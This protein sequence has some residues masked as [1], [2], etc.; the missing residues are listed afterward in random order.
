MLHVRSKIALSIIA[1]ALV[2]SGCKKL[3]ELAT[4]N[5]TI[6]YSEEADLPDIPRLT[7]TFPPSG[8]TISLPPFT[9]P[10]YSKQFAE[11][12]KTATNLITSVKARELS[13]DLLKPEDKTFDYV[14][15]LRL[16][17]SAPSIGERLVAYDYGIPK[18][19]KTIKMNPVDT[20]LKDMFAQDSMIFRLEG[21]FYD[22]PDSNTHVRMNASFNV[23]A[24][25]LN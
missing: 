11:E 24:N 17:A 23:S 1:T 16:Y 2:F 22:Y 10:T 3:K 21:H 6:D 20:D 5:K 9:I 13:L 25:P 8:V 4:I 18:G 19:Q 7:T 15:T 14:D 12:N